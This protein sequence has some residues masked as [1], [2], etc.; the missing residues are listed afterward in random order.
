MEGGG[1]LLL[2]LQ[3]QEKYNGAIY[4]NYIVTDD[5]KYHPKGKNRWSMI[6]C[7]HTRIQLVRRPC[8]LY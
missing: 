2:V 5:P 8:S 7:I 6:N 1:L 3:L 4:L